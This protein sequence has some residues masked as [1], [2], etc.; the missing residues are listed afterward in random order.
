MNKYQAM[1][2]ITQTYRVLFFIGVK[3]AWNHPPEQPQSTKN[4][5]KKGA[6]KWW[7]WL[8]NG[9]PLP[10]QQQEITGNF[11]VKLDLLLI[12]NG[13][14]RR[15]GDSL[16]AWPILFMQ[17]FLWTDP[18]EEEDAAECTTSSSTR[19]QRAHPFKLSRSEQIYRRNKVDEQMC[20][21]FTITW[22]LWHCRKS[23]FSIRKKHMK[24][25]VCPRHI[26]LGLLPP[27]L[28]VSLSVSSCSSFHYYYH[29]YLLSYAC[30]TTH[31]CVNK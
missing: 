6:M 7:V 26:N 11:N 13:E 9:Q 29:Y 30:S 22:C 18:G 4:P 1:W 17:E 15:I 8:M 27:S 16:H 5:R 14:G 12:Q 25:G 3:F 19:P 24:F 2:Q 23:L 20:E 21:V 28:P 31:M 10:N